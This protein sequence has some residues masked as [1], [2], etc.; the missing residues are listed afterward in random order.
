M[1]GILPFGSV[2]IELFFIMSALWLHQIYYVMG[3]FARS[4]AH[5]GRHVRASVDCHDLF[6]AM[7]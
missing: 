6:A 2:C 1:G 3:F 7:W 5:L 4:A